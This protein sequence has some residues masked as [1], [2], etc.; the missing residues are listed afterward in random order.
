MESEPGRRDGILLDF[1]LIGEV[2]MF[3]IN[4]RKWVSPVRCD[5]DFFNE[6]CLIFQ[7]L[8]K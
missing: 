3:H 5:K 7:M 4:P 8:I 6:L 1:A 2:K